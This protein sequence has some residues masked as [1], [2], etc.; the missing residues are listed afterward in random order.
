MAEASS[1]EIARLETL[2][3]EN[4]RGR[5]FTH[6]AEAHRK[7]GDPERAR[8]ILRRGL[9]DHPDYAS[10]HVVMGRIMEDLGDPGAAVSAFE[11]V[12]ALDPH[13]M[14]ALRR[15]AVAADE[16]GR[17]DDALAHWT[18]LNALDPGDEE[19]EARIDALSAPASGPVPMVPSAEASPP[20]AGVAGAYPESDPFAEEPTVFDERAAGAWGESGEW[21][22]AL[23]AEPLDGLIGVDTWGAPDLPAQRGAAS[24]EPG[25]S[26]DLGGVPETGT[27]ATDALNAQDALDDSNASDDSLPL[28]DLAVTDFGLPPSEEPPSEEPREERFAEAGPAG[29]VWPDLGPEDLDEGVGADEELSGMETETLGDLYAAQGL[30]ARAASVYRRMLERRPAD[31]RIQAKLFDA[32]ARVV[33]GESEPVRPEWGDVAGR[34]DAHSAAAPPSGRGSP[35]DAPAAAEPSGADAQGA[36]GAPLLEEEVLTA[37]EETP[38]PDAEPIPPF[39]FEAPEEEPEPLTFADPFA[40]GTDDGT[41]FGETQGAPDSPFGDAGLSPGAP[42]P[43]ADSAGRPPTDAS[44]GLWTGEEFSGT[45]FETMAGAPAAAESPEAARSEPTAA[46]VEGSGLE[47]VDLGAASA[48]DGPEAAISGAEAPGGDASGDAEAAAAAAPPGGDSLAA[49]LADALAQD[50]QGTSIRDTLQGLISW[51]PPAGVGV[52]DEPWTTRPSREEPEREGAP[53]AAQ[54]RYGLTQP[55]APAPARRAGP[56]REVDLETEPWAAAPSS[57]DPGAG[58]AILELGEADLIAPSAPPSDASRGFGE[59]ADPKPERPSPPETPPRDSDPAAAP[60]ELGDLARSLLDASVE[61]EAGGQVA[62]DSETGDDEELEV[63]RSW[64]QSLKK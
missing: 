28:I 18:A 7:N 14:I 36:A 55:Q 10:A 49:A 47:L 11:R 62:A 26:E 44:G 61:G 51:T 3:A 15:L 54:P 56:P 5:V 13:N 25:A 48:A 19:V 30:H 32:E 39:G 64:L 23:G 53:G 43:A 50:A 37:P 17:V 2:Y 34:P 59:R 60:E 42:P 12:L 27:G 24:D 29:W 52:D 45:P 35:A 6:L 41:A 20:D 22:E 31:A 46:D 4:P 21:E 38:L 58:E 33:A 57:R 40:Y 63:F 16:A 9:A 8:E 1:E